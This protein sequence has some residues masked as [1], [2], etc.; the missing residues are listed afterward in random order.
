MKP[1]IAAKLRNRIQVSLWILG[2]AVA[3]TTSASADSSLLE[4]SPFLPPGHGRAPEQTPQPQASDGPL[5]N[6]IEFR[7]VVR[8]SDQWLFSLYHRRDKRNFWVG[9]GEEHEQ[10]RVTDYDA[11]SN[12]LSLAYQGQSEWLM[13]KSP[14]DATSPAPQTQTPV[15]RAPGIQ[16]QRTAQDQRPALNRRRVPPREAAPVPRR[17]TPGN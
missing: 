11:D 15:L 9:L 17:T 7:S 1:P 10:F 8:L 14:G 5:S 13:I 12:R 6:L 4:N 16:R 2:T 3:L